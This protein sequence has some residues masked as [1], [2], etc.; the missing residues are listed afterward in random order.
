[1]DAADI[2]TG[3]LEFDLDD[4]ELGEPVFDL[5]VQR[6]EIQEELCG[7]GED[8]IPDKEDIKAE[9]AGIIAVNLLHAQ[10]RAGKLDKVTQEDYNDMRE[11]V[12]VDKAFETLINSRSSEE[13][14]KHATRD[15]GQDLYQDFRNALEMSQ[16]QPEVQERTGVRDLEINRNIAK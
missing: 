8:G 9:L 13:L 16:K 2:R 1:M 10:Q 7:L 3:V 11:S 6:L 15:K 4:V 14:F 5:D 12:E